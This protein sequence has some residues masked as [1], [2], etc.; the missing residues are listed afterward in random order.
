MLNKRLNTQT[1]LFLLCT[2]LLPSQ[3][4]AHDQKSH[5]K[6]LQKTTKWVGE[7]TEAAQLVKQFRT[8]LEQGDVSLAQSSLTENVL[9]F[10]GSGVERSAQEYASHHMLGDMKYLAAVRGELIE[11]QT[12]V[13]GDMAYSVSRTKMQGKYKGK[14]IDYTGVETI[15]LVNTDTGWKIAHIHWSK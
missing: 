14:A 2:L 10:E 3:V 6:S 11:Q 15:V 12:I 7:S 8:A 5:E 9:I 13:N 4:M 1:A